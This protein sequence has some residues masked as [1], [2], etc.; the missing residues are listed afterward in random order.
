MRKL[1]IIPVLFLSVALIGCG[2]ADNRPDGM[3]PLFPT[4]ITVTQ[5]GVPLVGASVVLIPD[6]GSRDWYVSG[7]TNE[8]GIAEMMAS[9]RWAGAPRGTYKVM[10]RKFETA[11]SRIAPLPDDA[12]DAAREAHEV[13]LSNERLNAYTVVAPIFTDP[14]R[15]TLN[16]TVDGRTDTTF[17]VGEAVRVLVR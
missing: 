4:T 11:P 10:V 3:P 8:S 16:L 13:A 5:D 7:T 9:S 2:P 17:D 1:Y 12:D 15:T 6:D 14:A